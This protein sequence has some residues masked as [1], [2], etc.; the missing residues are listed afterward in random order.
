M[1][2][3]RMGSRGSIGVGQLLQQ[4]QLTDGLDQ[5]MSSPKGISLEGG[6]ASSLVD[7]KNAFRYPG[8][9]RRDGFQG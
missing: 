2:R 8:Y 6:Q 7:Q 3:V 9:F 4:L 5:H 1:R